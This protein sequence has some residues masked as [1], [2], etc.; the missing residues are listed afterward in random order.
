MDRRDLARIEY[1]RRWLRPDWRR[2][3]RPDWERHVNPA[4]GEAM[5]KDFALRDRAFETPMARRWR[6]ENEAREREEQERRG[7]EHQAEIE[8]E[9]LELKADL[10]SLRFELVWTEFCRRAEFAERKRRADIAW[11]RF[12]ATFMRGDFAPH[13]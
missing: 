4:E 5:R 7:A 10:A 8:R 9:T 6:E 12:K 1:Y 13:R 11:E 3:L 2:W